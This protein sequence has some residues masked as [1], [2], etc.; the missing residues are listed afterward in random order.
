MTKNLQKTTFFPGH[1]TTCRSD[2]RPSMMIN[3]SYSATSRIM[4][5]TLPTGCGMIKPVFVSTHEQWEGQGN[6]HGHLINDPI[7]FWHDRPS[8]SLAKHLQTWLGAR[9]EWRAGRFR[10]QRWPC[11]C[12]CRASSTPP[13]RRAW[14]SAWRPGS[15]RDS[16]SSAG[17]PRR[18]PPLP[19]SCQEGIKQMNVNLNI[20]TC[21]TWGVPLSQMLGKRQPGGH[22]R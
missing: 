3:Q 11:R 1:R 16:P 7:E 17:R 10:Q 12:S 20:W 18:A 14:S 22:E 15:C 4:T 9:R 8:V 2:G 6:T 5:A 19:S 21:S 13:R